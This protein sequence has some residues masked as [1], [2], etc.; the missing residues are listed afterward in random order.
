MNSYDQNVHIFRQNCKITR[1]K[2]N[3]FWKTIKEIFPIKA[4]S[5]SS[6]TTFKVGEKFISDKR[7][8]AEE[9][10]K[11]FSSVASKLKIKGFPLTNF[12]WR[13]RKPNLRNVNKFK[14][15]KISELD[16]LK[17]LKNLK[18]KCATGLDNIPTCFLKDTAYVISQLC[19][20]LSLKTGV[21][22]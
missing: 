2:P 17:H 9:F 3:H 1:G 7:T 13:F 10:C 4:T 20:K 12:V 15:H 18:R 8:I 11:F 19:Y 6:S 16:I 22:P 21:F 14:F 5:K